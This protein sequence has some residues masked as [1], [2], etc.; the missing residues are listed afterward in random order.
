[1]ADFY[2][3]DA[4]GLNP[5]MIP[6]MLQ[7]PEIAATMAAQKGTPPIMPGAGQAPAFGGISDLAKMGAAIQP[8]Q[9][10]QYQAP[11]AVNPGQPQQGG[12]IG[13]PNVMQLLQQLLAGRQPGG[14][15]TGLGAAVMGR[16]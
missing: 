2:N 5:A 15:G 8:P 7:S 14:A 6:L 16:R 10:P 3:P 4:M 9:A 12:N 13:A 11:G 1:M